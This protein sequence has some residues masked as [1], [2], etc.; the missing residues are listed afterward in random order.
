[1][2]TGVEEEMKVTSNEERNNKINQL[3]PVIKSANHSPFISLFPRSNS[4]NNFHFMGFLELISL[5]PFAKSA[6]F[7][8]P[9]RKNVP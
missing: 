8:P 2:V 7:F 3:K 1:M 4:P 6:F 9:V 5:T